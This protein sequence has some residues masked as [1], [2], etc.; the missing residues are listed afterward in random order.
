MTLMKWRPMGDMLTVHDRINRLFEDFY[1]RES[2]RSGDIS[3]SWFPVT[4]I[5]ENKDD[6][7]FRL[8]VP[9]L[10]KEDIKIEFDQSTIK[11]RGEK[12]E[13]KGVNRENCH[14]VESF[15]GSFERS[16]VLP[17]DVDAQKISAEMKNGI[18]E[19]RVPKIEEKKARAIPITVK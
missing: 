11:I 6:Y 18:L 14:R 19:L 13:E 1:N 4:D 3:S 7:V 9:G 5:Y 12:L 8:E 17:K 2:D 10:A 15:S 16:F